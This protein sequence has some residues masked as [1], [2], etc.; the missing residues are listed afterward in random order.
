MLNGKL[1][2]QRLVVLDADFRVR[3]GDEPVELQL[4]VQSLV[5]ASKLVYVKFKPLH[6]DPQHF[7]RRLTKVKSLSESICL[8]SQEFLE[9]ADKLDLYPV[10]IMDFQEVKLPHYLLASKEQFDVLLRQDFIGNNCC[11]EHV[12]HVGPFIVAVVKLF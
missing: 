11:V 7:Y 2:S 9:L 3:A 1:L 5:E 8:G 6:V 4:V 12:N 10:V